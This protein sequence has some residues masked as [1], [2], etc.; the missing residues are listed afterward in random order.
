MCSTAFGGLARAQAKALG[1]PDQ[2]LLII[3]HPFGSRSRE[4]VAA[5]AETLAE[6][7]AETV[8]LAAVAGAARAGSHIG[9]TPAAGAADGRLIELPADIEAFHQ[10]CSDR[11]WSD[12]LPVIPPTPAR[13]ARMLSGSRR[14]PTA[15]VATLAPGFGAATV[16]LI[17]VNAVMAGCLPAHLPVLIAAVEAAA[18]PAF[19]LQAVQSTTN[20]VTTWLIVNGPIALALG[21]NAG[22]N[23]LGQGNLPNATLGRALRLVM[24]NIGGAWPAEMDRATHGQPGKFLFCCAEN[25]AASPWAPLHADRG[26]ATGDD[27]V[28]LVAASGTLN[29]NTHSKDADELL[30]CL[31]RSMA[32]PASNDYH[33]CGEPWMILSPEHA[34]V[35]ARHGYDKAAVRRMLWEQ[36]MMV[37]GEFAQRDYERTRNARLG[38]LP[39]FDRSTRVPLSR[40]PEDVGIVVAGGPGTHSV[41]VPTFGETRAVTRRIE[42]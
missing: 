7:I 22:I 20:P 38:E 30:A 18:D 24:Q 5:L 23:C 42:A 21:M 4:E 3:E 25:E 13:V 32:Y 17:A 31:A 6:R 19:N 16:E 40:S 39:G 36:S 29:L 14:A 12:G 26:F 28:T 2:P 41:Y 1:A 37:A 9:A 35:M 27:A 11:R 8:R 33:Y 34:A 10:A 15:V